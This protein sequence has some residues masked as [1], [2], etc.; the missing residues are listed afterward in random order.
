MFG[1]RTIFYIYLSRNCG[2]SVNVLLLAHGI[3]INVILSL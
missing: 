2:L 1:F 3:D